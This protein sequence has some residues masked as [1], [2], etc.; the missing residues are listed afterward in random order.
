MHF[1]LAS[2]NILPLNY[3]FS[4]DKWNSVF[5][6]V[7]VTKYRYSVLEGDIKLRCRSLLIQICEAEDIQILKGVVSKDHMHLEYLPTKISASL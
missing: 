6:I 5:H 2:K 3:G 7:L 1:A 4:E